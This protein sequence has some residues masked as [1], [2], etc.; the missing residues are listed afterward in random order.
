[1]HK[2]ANGEGYMKIQTIN[3]KDGFPP[4]D[5]AVANLEISIEAYSKTDTKVLK[6]IHGHGSH[7]VGGEIRL[8]AR[9]RL[10]ELKRFHKIAD[11]IPGEKF[12]E[13][14]KNSEYILENFPELIL[15]TDLKN[16]N[17]GITLVFLKN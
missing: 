15:D 17:S 14:T 10:E 12:G 2:Y 9:Q 8:L 1:M 6:V 7:G 4:S 5:V 13:S 3:I 11:F 16:Y